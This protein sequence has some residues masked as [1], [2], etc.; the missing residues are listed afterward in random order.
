M[1]Y[2]YYYSKGKTIHTKKTTHSHSIIISTESKRKG[3]RRPE[4]QISETLLMFEA[5]Y[6]GMTLIIATRLS[7]A[8]HMLDIPRNL[9]LIYLCHL[10][11]EGKHEF[12]R[13]STERHPDPAKL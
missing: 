1:H 2:T 8:T 9:D 12:C 10:N 3:K 5:F 11:L 6:F 13:V 7:T 4:R